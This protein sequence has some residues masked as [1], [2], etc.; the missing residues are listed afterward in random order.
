MSIYFIGDLHLG[1][2]N[3][4]SFDNRPFRNIEEHDAAIIS[5]WNNKVAPEDDVYILG[6]VS[7]HNTKK[8][9]EQIKLLNGHKHLIVGNHD[10]HLLK[11]K[12]FKKLFVEITNY[13]ELELSDGTKIVLC[14]YPIPCFRNHYYNWY[15]LYAH[16]HKSFEWHMMERIKYEM[17]NLYDK[18]CRMYNVGAM[19]DYMGYTPRT[20][21]EIVKAH[22]PQFIFKIEN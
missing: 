21:L 1:H 8:S 7:W 15:H 2:K 6:D 22:A 4:L 16:V 17:E 11:N 14:H 19:L 10:A 20:L 12:E 3:I 9:I 5:N 18:Q 13:K